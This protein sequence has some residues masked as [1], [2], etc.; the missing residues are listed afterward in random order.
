MAYYERVNRRFGHRAQ[1]MI[2]LTTQADFR[3]VQTLSFC[4]LCGEDFAPGDNINRDHVPPQSAIAKRDREPLCLPTHVGCN[5]LHQLT[6]EKIGQLIALRRS[7][8]PKR[9]ARRLRFALSKHGAHGAVTNLR[10][11]VAVWRWVAGFHAALYRTSPMGIRGSLVTPFPRGQNLGGTVVIEALKP[12]HQLI[13]H[14]IKQNRARGNL[15]RINCNKGNVLYDCVW[16]QSDNQGPW[17]CMFALDIY[18]WK[19]LGRTEG[20]PAR[21]CAGHYVLPS[22]GV[23]INAARNITSRLYIP[24]ID[25]F[26]PFGR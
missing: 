24:V 5:G 21:G 2:S 4:Y 20:L 23:P 15:D 25:R 7:E 13:V 17:M 6:D 3:G 14:T 1:R 19:D 8:L 11:D 18:D 22:N 9:H 10:V 26:D 16:C 12:Q